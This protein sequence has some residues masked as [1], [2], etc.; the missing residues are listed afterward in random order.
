MTL[1]SIVQSVCDEIGF[2]SVAA[3]AGATDPLGRQFYALANKELRELSKWYDWPVLQRTYTLTVVA[4]TD[5]YA[6][7]AGFRKIAAGTAYRNSDYW[8]LRGSVT[9]G[10]WQQ[11][12]VELLSSLDRSVFRIFGNPSKI[13][14][15]PM[16]TA[17]GSVVFEY[18]SQNYAVTNVP[19][20]IP[21]YA[22]DTDTAIVSE[23]LVQMGLLWRIKHAKGLEFGADIDEY[24]AA[25]PKAFSEAFAQPPIPIGGPVIN[26][27]LTYGYVPDTGF[28]V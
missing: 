27:P 22:A 11:R 7:P 3:V 1:L 23:E 13:V 24:N 9:P 21:Q 12:R 15:D 14:L 28:G 26:S 17:A 19:A 10:E 25:V 20:E 5:T 2:P 4:A 6:L 18:Q 8:M 16:P